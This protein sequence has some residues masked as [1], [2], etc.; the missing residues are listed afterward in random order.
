M[1]HKPK[2][3]VDSDAMPRPLKEAIQK[4]AE[5]SGIQT[6]FVAA[7][8]PKILE[9][10]YIKSIGAGK[11]FNGADDW[12]AENV[13]EGDLVVTADIPLA[14]RAVTKGAE[15]LNTKGEFF[16]HANI[17]TALA[18]RD[19]LDELRVSGEIT[20]GPPPFSDRQRI[21]FINSLNKFIQKKR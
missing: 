20:S 3:Y 1:P 2:I 8:A 9:N 5:R 12:I 10:Q 4:A 13:E 11:A 6:F 7:A 14:D 15:V 18:M 19:L 17:K 21:V 16:T